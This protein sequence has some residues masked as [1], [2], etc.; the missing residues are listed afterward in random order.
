MKI[1]IFTGYDHDKLGDEVN[2]WT[3][4]NSL[5][6]FDTKYSTVMDLGGS[7][8]YTVL[9]MYKEKENGC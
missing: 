5:F 9:V 4:Q 8:W 2:K 1:K 7:C 3:E 6:V